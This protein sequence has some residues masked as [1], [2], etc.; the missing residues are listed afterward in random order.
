MS[1]VIWDLETTIR[2]SFKRKANPFDRDNF[3]V[4]QGYKRFGGP[5]VGEYYGKNPRPSNWF[6]QLIEPPAPLVRPKMLVGL[7]IKFDLLHA[8]QEPDN[9]AAWMRFVAAGGTVWDCQLA[10]YLLEGMAPTEHMLSMDEIAPRY[11]GNI[12]F[13]EVK[14][15]W[16]A[17]VSTEDIDPAL[18]RRYLCGTDTEHGD[19][20]NTEV[21][22]LGQLA[23]AKASGQMKSMM[24]NMGSLLCT[25]EMEL[26]GM[27]VDVELGK[28]QAEQLAI[29]LAALTVE[30]N[31]F[32]P[33]DLPFEFKWSSRVQK[34][35]LIFGGDVK[36]KARVP[37]VDDDGKQV[38][39]QKKVPGLQRQLDGEWMPVEDWDEDTHGPAVTFVSGRNKGEVKTKQ[40]TVNDLSKPKSRLEDFTYRFPQMTEPKKQWEGSTPGVYSVSAEVIKG[41][42]NRGIPFLE[43]LAKVEGLAKDLGTYYIVTDPDTGQQKGMLTLVQADGIIHHMLNHTSTVTG[44]FSSSNP[45]LQNLP[46]DGKS[47]VKSVF[48]SRFGADGKVI[49]SDFTSLEVYIQAILTDCKQLILDLKAGLDMHCVR[50]SQ[51]EGITYEEALRLC[52]KEKVKEWASKRTKAK[53]FSFQRAY[54]AGAALIAESTGMPREEVDALIEAEN[55]RYPEIEKFYERLT[56][57]IMANSV[58][59]NKF[60]QHPDLPHLTCN[61]RKSTYQTPDGKIYSYRESPAPEFLAKAPASRGGCTTSFSPTEIK[62]YVVQGS[63]GEW[64]KAAMWLAVRAFYARANFGGRGL[65]VN[66]VHDA[67]Y[68]DAASEVA[69]EVAALL[70]ACMEAASEFMEYYFDWEV[71]VPVPSDTTWGASMIEESRMP[72]G[73]MQLVRPL[74]LELRTTYMGGYTPSFE[75]ENPN[76]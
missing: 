71:K 13:D 22:F 59:T 47:V 26:N 57:K 37:I 35:A 70:H 14:A 53:V 21:I 38:Y 52:V 18:L 74:R 40:L 75:Q 3:V 44:R 36:Y 6:I 16:E 64:A 7:N 42:A 15:L 69:L 12:K 67:L 30:L 11:G 50:V 1:Y 72:E 25:T 29:D 41:L 51:K 33:A 49:Q 24:L 17:G 68:A 23:R 66:Q 31:A 5:V 62:N 63:G 73:F 4:M 45:N 76:G 60:A 56:K 27:A 34:S 2:T 48:V 43:S 61:F 32:L 39:T 65:L 28:Q 55:T 46:K 20:G 54:G 10:E 9:R 19:I 58:P 8:L